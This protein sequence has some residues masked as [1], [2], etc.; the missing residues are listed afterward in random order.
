MLKETTYTNRGPKD[1]EEQRGEEIPVTAFDPR[2]YGEPIV[3]IA[4]RRFPRKGLDGHGAHRPQVPSRIY[5]HSSAG[6]R[7]VVILPPRPHAIVA[8]P[9]EPQPP[10]ADGRLSASTPTNQ[11]ATPRKTNTNMNAANFRSTWS[12]WTELTIRFYGLPSNVSTG[13]IY[14]SLRDL[15]VEESINYIEIYEAGNEFGARVI[16]R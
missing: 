11:I 7:P 1:K 2:A 10:A 16:F 15:G 9:P 12:E 6:G 8:A 3:S 5:L 4:R 13:Q 14:Y